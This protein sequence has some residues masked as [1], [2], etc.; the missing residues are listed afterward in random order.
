MPVSRFLSASAISI[1]AA[2]AW[3]APAAFADDAAPPPKAPSLKDR[4]L[5]DYV[6][7]WRAPAASDSRPAED[8]EDNYANDAGD[9]LFFAPGVWINALDLSEP[10]IVMRG[11][12]VGNRQERSTVVAL[13]DGAPLTDVHGDTNTAEIDLLSVAQVDIF[14]GGA[15]DLLY[16]GDNL[17]GVIN[18]I[19]PTGRT[20]RA[21]R[22]ARFDGGAFINGNPGG[23]AHADMAGVSSSGNLDF[24]AGVTGRYESGFRDNNQRNDLIFNANL[25]YEASRSFRTRVFV[26]A[27]RSDM[28]LAGGLL[29]SDALDDPSAAMP[30]I[31][32]G[33]LF[34][35]GPIIEL[36]D[37]AEDGEHGR[38]LLVGRLS[39]V[40]EFRLL[41][42]DFEGG[43]HFARR[44]IEAPQIS[45][46]GVIDESGNEWGANLAASRGFR[47]FGLETDVK[48]GGAY[49]TGSKSSNR[50][51]NLDGE[52][53]D[54]L[55]ETD[56]KSS[57]ITGFID[58]MTRPFKKMLVTIGAKF[59]RTTRQLT[60]DDDADKETFTGVTARGGVSYDLTKKV[61]AF[62]NASRTYEP[63]SFS[64]LVSDNPEA[65]NGLGE[66][67]AFTYEAGLRGSVNDWLGWDIT[68]FNSDIEGEIV[69]V[70]EPET[71]GLGG[72]LVN[73]NTSR[74]RGVEAGLD[75]NLFPQRFARRGA[76]LT[77]RNAYSYNDFRFKD[78]GALP[79]DGDRLAGIPQH[80][81]RGELR[82]TVDGKWYAGVNLQKVAG[83]FYADHVNAVSIPTY[84]LVGFSAGMMM[85]DN[86]ELYASGENLTDQNY[87]AGIT[88]VLSQ[89]AQDGRIFTPGAGAAVYGGI[90]YRF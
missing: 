42:L 50:F 44:Q 52:K 29:P 39:N 47:L 10:R 14:R 35:G 69:N 37:G 12:G 56:Q 90:R 36:A 63:P 78:A 40:T 67:D 86:L 75:L 70:E 58:A 54:D 46:I 26:E 19:S 3:R 49:A 62:A 80:V 43:A 16:G 25:G 68:Y 87:A 51:E 9:A 11:F 6:E 41:G 55:F 53:G 72:V 30:P 27:L 85:S 1:C 15:G 31:T 17:G 64:E 8:F 66:Q 74:H 2:M 71:N 28:E 22:S 73:V 20:A 18:F 60:V 33:P 61:Q 45:F 65:F 38:N 34:P 24:Y 5:E 88:P 59:V 81:Y 77:L 79:V 84:T 48:L 21:N 32:L 23:Q 82:Y 76:A 57:K 89:A 7:E 83:A 13:R 4:S